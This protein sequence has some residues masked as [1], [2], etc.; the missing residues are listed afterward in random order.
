M[1]L[2]NEKSGLNTLWEED[3]P[4]LAISNKLK[5]RVEV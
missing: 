3:C 4:N 2:V 1:F 5:R